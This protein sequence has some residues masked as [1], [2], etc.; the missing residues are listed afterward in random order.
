MSEMAPAALGRLAIV[1]AI[2][3]VGIGLHG[4]EPE[5]LGK[6]RS[7]I[8]TLEQRLA[9]LDAEAMTVREERERLQAELELARA[10]V[11]ENELLLTRSRDEIVRI[12]SGLEALSTELEQRHGALLHHLEMLALLGGPG[13]L[14]LLADAMAGGDLERATATVS[15][16]TAGHLRLLE[17]YDQL[18][19]ERSERLAELSR[20]IAAAERE[21]LQLVERR[22]ELTETRE[23]VESRLGELDRSQRSAG[24][25]LED[26]RQREQA[27]ER[28][29][30]L[31]ATRDRPPA[32]DDIRRYRGALPWPVPGRVVRGFGRHYLP[33]YATYTVCN[34]LRL[35]VAS[36][37]P[38]QSVF[39]G[40]V[41]YAQF[42]KG[43][44]N[45]VVVDHGHGVYSLVAG[46]ATLHVRLDHRVT[47]GT[48]LGQASPPS[49]DGNLYFEIRVGETPQDPRRWLQLEDR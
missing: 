42:F 10:R 24:N 19:R 5:Q 32:N 16:L 2:L 36:G 46:L 47:M 17:E 11:L 13:P 44:G 48:R 12:R 28:L 31:L 26:L 25:R 43:Y 45:M 23:R 6:V 4:A 9:S 35:S 34:G 3:A 37:T 22:A 8:R 39:P 18:Q 27:L 21:A 14:Q 33:R 1:L 40:V 49:D 7:E 29:M 15:V 41:A 30:G 20:I 38:V